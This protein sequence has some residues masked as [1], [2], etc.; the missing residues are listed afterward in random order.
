MGL[1]FLDFT[2]ITKGN[3]EKHQNKNAFDARLLTCGS[4]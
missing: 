4:L 1:V 2:H 3:D